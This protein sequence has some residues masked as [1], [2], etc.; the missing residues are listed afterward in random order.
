MTNNK[1]IT[2]AALIAG[3]KISFSVPL[4]CKGL[5]YAG[6]HAQY[7]PLV[8]KDGEALEGITLKPRK[9]GGYTVECSRIIIAEGGRSHVPSGMWHNGF[10][11]TLTIKLETPTLA[12]VTMRLETAGSD[13]QQFIRLHV[14]DDIEVINAMNAL[15]RTREAAAKAF[16]DASVILTPAELEKF[17]AWRKEKT[18]EN[19]VPIA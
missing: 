3:Q 10:K 16:I 5:I 19:K 13:V 6:H 15:R 1:V 11:Y 14:E 7:F 9:S 4:V 17:K 8:N 2:C 12:L 18:A